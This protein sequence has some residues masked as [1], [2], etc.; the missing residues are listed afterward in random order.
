MSSLYPGTK[1][2]KAAG[3]NNDLGSSPSK[4]DGD[5]NF[6][7]KTYLENEFAVDL[8]FELFLP[9]CTAGSYA[10]EPRYE[11]VFDEMMDKAIKVFDVKQYN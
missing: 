3:F 11:K 7:L 10:F 8:K 4:I 6:N 9:I 5:L 1:S 2:S